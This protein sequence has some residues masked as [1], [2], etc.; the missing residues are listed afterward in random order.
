MC[1]PHTGLSFFAYKLPVNI[2][3]RHTSAQGSPRAAPLH[4][5]RFPWLFRYTGRNSSLPSLL[6]G[7][8]SEFLD[9]PVLAFLLGHSFAL[10]IQEIK[11]RRHHLDSYN[12]PFVKLFQSVRDFLTRFLGWFGSEGREWGS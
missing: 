9:S 12:D 4:W 11:V 10:S 2:L 5:V 1:Q 3:D 7:R 6:S 8:F